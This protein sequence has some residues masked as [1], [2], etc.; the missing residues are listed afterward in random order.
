MQIIVIDGSFHPGTMT[1][2][3]ALASIEKETTVFMS[4]GLTLGRSNHYCE[5]YACLKAL[6]FAKE[7]YDPD[8]PIHI[9]SDSKNTLHALSK[10]IENKILVNY[11]RIPPWDLAKKYIRYFS[12]I[13]SEFKGKMDDQVCEDVHF[14]AKKEMEE[15]RTKV[16]NKHKQSEDWT[17][18]K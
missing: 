11:R 1:G 17:P 13:T 7:N 18:V 6:A 12:K 5:D 4:G 2:G 9:I 10:Q 3:W 16:I 15:Q 8:T 14:L